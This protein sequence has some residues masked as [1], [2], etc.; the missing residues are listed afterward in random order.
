MQCPISGILFYITLYNFLA[1][2]TR[3][4]RE[5]FAF[6]WENWGGRWH[7]SCEGRPADLALSRKTRASGR[8]PR[9]QKP[10]GVHIPEG[11]AF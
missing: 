1:R 9:N 3:V 6:F 11:I 2:D 4:M 8:S 7:G 10:P 5:F